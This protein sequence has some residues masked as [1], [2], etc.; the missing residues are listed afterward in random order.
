MRGRCR[1]CREVAARLE[2]PGGTGCS[3]GGRRTGCR[4]GPRRRL[5]SNRLSSDSLH[6]D[7]QPGFRC[8]VSPGLHRSRGGAQADGLPGCQLRSVT[9][10]EGGRVPPIN[11]TPER[12][13]HLGAQPEPEP[14]L[15]HRRSSCCFSGR[16]Y[17][18][19]RSRAVAPPALVILSAKWG[20][21]APPRSHSEAP[22]LRPGSTPCAV[23]LPAH[24][25][26]WA[27]GSADLGRALVTCLRATQLGWLGRRA[28]CR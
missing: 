19:G 21:R 12:L 24:A 9:D 18:G 14:C 17:D 8:A 15:P 22:P 2:G 26:G 7:R 10:E 11:R 4:C 20:P 1:M 13:S 3:W 5:W 28:V 6:R 23:Y 25:S 27:E 16:S